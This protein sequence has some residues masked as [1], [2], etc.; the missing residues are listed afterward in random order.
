MFKITKEVKWDAAHRLWNYEG[1]CSKLHGHSFRAILTFENEDLNK[2]G[3]VID[4]SVVK[5]IVQNWVNQHWDHMLILNMDD[6]IIGILNKDPQYRGWIYPMEG[7]PT[8]E[9]MAKLLFTIFR[10]EF[11]FLAGRLI[12]VEVFEGPKSSAIYYEE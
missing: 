2:D 5:K 1:K 9:N 8:A 12:S 3:M 4:F 10:H 7:N 11:L 6:S